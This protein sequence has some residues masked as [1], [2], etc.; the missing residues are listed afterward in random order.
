[1]QH[2]GGSTPRCE[3]SACPGAA[4]GFSDAAQHRRNEEKPIRYPAPL[5]ESREVKGTMVLPIHGVT[6]NDKGS[7]WLL[8]LR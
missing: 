3:A 8:G 7:A 1:M 4:E 2:D 5:S 6:F